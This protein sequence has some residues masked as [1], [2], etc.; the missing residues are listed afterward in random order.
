MKN[1]LNKVHQMSYDELLPLIANQSVHAV[2]TDPPFGIA[3][4]NNY[5]KQRHR[6]LEGDGQKFSYALLGKECYRILKPNTAILCFTGWSEYPQHFV[7][8]QTAGFAMKEPI[9]CQKRPS[10]K[11]DLFGT[12]QSNADWCM[13]GHKGR[14][15]FRKTELMRNKR[16]GTIP[17]KGR[18]PVP[19]YKTRFPSCWFGE[20]FPWSSENSAFQKQNE[21]YHPTI[22]GLDFIK[23]LILLTTNEGDTVLDPFLGSGT[24]AVAASQLNRNFIGCEIDTEH[25]QTAIKRLS[26]FA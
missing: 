23:W 15:V 3:Y 10:G 18:K 9:I 5:T 14:F 2:I 20:Q 16:A 19:D 12:F 21:I 4:Q 17:N 7:E 22:K 13:F 11:T 25:C 6:V 24:T 8:L 26:D 1:L